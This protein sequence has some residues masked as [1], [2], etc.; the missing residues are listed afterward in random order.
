MK[1]ILFAVASLFTFTT[2]PAQNVGINTATPQ[3]TLDVNG[4]TKTNSLTVAN[5]GNQSDFLV[6]TDVNGQVGFKKGHSAVAGIR[7][8]ICI[9][10]VFPFPGMTASAEGYIGEI[11]MF[12]IF[13]STYIPAGWKL[14]NG[15]V[16]PINQN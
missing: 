6:K 15:D 11:R 14:C 4:T 12:A 13:D 9:E 2:L 16:L 5:G 10:G 7:Y 1:R 8:I 3:A